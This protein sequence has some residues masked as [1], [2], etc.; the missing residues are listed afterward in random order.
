MTVDKSLSRRRFLLA[1]GTLGVLGALGAA[2]PAFARRPEWTWDPRGSLGRGKPGPEPQTDPEFVWDDVADPVVAQI[3]IDG[4]VQEVN[5][6]LRSWTR[7]D[8]S[9]SGLPGYVRDFIDNA[10]QL[11]D[12]CRS[13]RAGRRCGTRSGRSARPTSSSPGTAWPPSS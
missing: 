4:K 2:T 6:V 11:P 5:Q 3:Y 7:N 8:Q 9:L 1:G 12:C 13:P 10:R